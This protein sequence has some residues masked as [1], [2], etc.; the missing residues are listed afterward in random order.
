MIEFKNDF[1]HRSS[2]VEDERGDL[3]AHS[4]STLNIWIKHF[5]QLLDVHGDN[6]VRQTKIHTAEPLVPEHSAFEIEIEKLKRYK[7]PGTDQIPAEFLQAGGR[8][9]FKM[10]KVIV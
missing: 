1:L 5:C 3:L 4:H 8:I 7:S 10:H 2:F 9:C 6:G